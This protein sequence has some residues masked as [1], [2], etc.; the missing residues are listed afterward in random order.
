MATR[1]SGTFTDERADISANRLETRENVIRLARA[2]CTILL[3]MQ[4]A[5]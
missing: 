5:L 1:Y 4:T 2:L 3:T